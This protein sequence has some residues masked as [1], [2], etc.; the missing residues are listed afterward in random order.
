MFGLSCYLISFDYEF[1]TYV[2]SDE[3]LCYIGQKSGNKK[4]CP[5]SYSYNYKYTKD[6]PECWKDI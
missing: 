3:E 2:W 4:R 1:E 6:K 5:C